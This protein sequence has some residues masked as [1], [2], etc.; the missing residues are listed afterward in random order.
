[1]R[2]THEE[3]GKDLGA[4]YSSASTGWGYEWSEQVTRTQLLPKHVVVWHLEREFSAT[5]DF[6]SSA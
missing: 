5:G 6:S 4:E 3:G 2:A 1:M